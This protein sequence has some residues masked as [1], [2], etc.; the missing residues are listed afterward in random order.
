MAFL[1]FCNNVPLIYYTISAALTCRWVVFHLVSHIV[2]LHHCTFSDD[3]DLHVL[4]GRSEGTWFSLEYSILLGCNT[5][6]FGWV[7][8]DSSK[9]HSP[10]IFRVFRLWVR[11]LFLHLSFPPAN[12]CTVS[13]IIPSIYWIFYSICGLTG[14]LLQIYCYDDWHR[15]VSTSS[16]TSPY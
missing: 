10:F 4:C 16:I 8:P 13:K 15:A 14:L 12:S 9:D 2:F 11:S 1:S 5:V 6:L 7:F 3:T